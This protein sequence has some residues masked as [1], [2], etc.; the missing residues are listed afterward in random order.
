MHYSISR[1][2]ET[3]N[4]SAQSLRSWENQGLIPKPE[5]RPTGRREYS[6]DDI[7]AIKEY[8]NNR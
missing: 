7:E 5:R 4:V 2:A 3:I 1:V 8:L 6:D